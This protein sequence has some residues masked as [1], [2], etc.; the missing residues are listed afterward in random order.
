[1]SIILPIYKPYSILDLGCGSGSWLHTISK[2]Y[3]ISDFLGVDGHWIEENELLIPQTNF[4]AHNLQ[5]VYTPDRKYDMAISMEVAEHL[6]EEFAEN[7]VTSL[8][9]SSDFILFSAAIP[10]QGGTNHVNEKKQSYWKYIFSKQGYVCLDVIRPR[11]WDLEGVR[12]DYKQNTLLYIKKTLLEDPNSP[13]C[14]F[15]DLKNIKNIDIVHPE[16]FE[17]RLNVE[18]D[19]RVIGLKKVIKAL[20]SLIYSALKKRNLN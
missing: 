18:S 19:L 1:M 8:T 15:I 13:L 2:E 7:F 10:Y 17:R 12:T 4:K 5:D 3:K 20:P 6:D 9:N 16:L 11:I 14:K